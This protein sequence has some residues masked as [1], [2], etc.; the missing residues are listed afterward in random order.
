[1]NRVLIVDDSES[2]RY[3]LATWLRRAG[4][5]VLEAATG[6]EA[7]RIFGDGLLDLVVLDINLPDMSG[8]QVCEAIKANLRPRAVPVLHV[9]ATATEPQDRSEGLR[10]GADGY[11]VEPVEREELLASVEALLRG[12]AAQRTALRLAYRLRQLNDATLAINEAATLEH[13][14]TIIA[15]QACRVFETSTLVAVAT[16]ESGF[17]ASARPGDEAIFDASVPE[18]VEALR[19]AAMEYKPVPGDLLGRFVPESESGLFR[20]ADLS[21]SGGHRGTLFVAIPG[22]AEG[23]LPSDETDVVL[24]QFARAAAAAIRNMRS[25]DIERHIA[26]TL[27]QNLLPDVMPD[28]PGLDVAARYKASAEHAEVGGD[29]YEVFSLGANHVCVAIGDVIGH[30]L[31]A[32]AVMAQLRTGIRSYVLEGH[33]PRGVLGRLNKLLLRFHPDITATVCCAVFDR[34][35]GACELANA[36][37]PPPLLKHGAEVTFLPNGGPLLGIEATPIQP[38]RFTLVSGDVLLLFTDGLV[39]R[40]HEDLDVSLLRL[41]TV[42][43]AGIDEL[44]ELCDR[45]LREAGPASLTDDIALVAIRPTR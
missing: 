14:V 7:L 18:A 11:L 35:T 31:D 23:D 22:P 42:M 12:A 16:P 34:T 43:T 10:R 3:V 26:L 33:G 24:E 29:F 36:G 2:N 6:T 41:A 20:S 32:A 25:Y 37:H 9:S 4:Y 27:Q 39:E 19:R 40:R 8:Y 13:L 45:I 15:R 44:D 21:E 30:S 5:D 17:M 28:I 1:M 38:H